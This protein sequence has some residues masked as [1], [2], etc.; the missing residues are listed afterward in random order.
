MRDRVVERLFSLFTSSD[1]AEAI[2]GDLAEE[3]DRRGSAWFWLHA[4]GVMLALWRRAAADAPLRVL[5]S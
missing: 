1:R 5:A 4:A 3:R 2:A